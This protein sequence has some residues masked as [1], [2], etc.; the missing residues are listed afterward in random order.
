MVHHG[1]VRNGHNQSVMN[2]TAVQLII[3]MHPAK[4]KPSMVPYVSAP[5]PVWMCFEVLNDLF[6]TQFLV[7]RPMWRV[8]GILGIV[9]ILDVHI[10][11]DPLAM[12]LD[13]V[14]LGRWLKRWVGL[15]GRITRVVTVP[16][17]F[18]KR[19]VTIPLPT[20]SF[21]VPQ[22]RVCQSWQKGSDVSCRLRWKK[23]KRCCGCALSRVC[24][25]FMNVVRWKDHTTTF[26]DDEFVFGVPFRHSV[27]ACF[28][29]AKCRKK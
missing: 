18:D 4:C 3:F 27:N 5:C 13:V 26:G 12:S 21:A 2:F 8:L 16:F 19:G 11:Q 28:V 17:C 25:C 23:I 1:V 7:L 6:Q 9:G 24:Y 22:M 20:T 10:V 29:V 14:D 15:L